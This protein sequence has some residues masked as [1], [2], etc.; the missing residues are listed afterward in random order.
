M[1]MH[2]YLYRKALP[3]YFESEIGSINIGTCKSIQLRKLNDMQQAC[4]Y[5]VTHKK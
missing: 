5:T 4:R 2:K 3:S 1:N